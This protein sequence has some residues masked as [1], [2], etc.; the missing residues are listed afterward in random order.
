MAYKYQ[1]LESPLHIRLIHLL[2]GKAD[3]DIQLQISHELL[4]Q[5][6]Q[7]IS[8]RLSWRQLEQTLPPKWKVF[9]TLEGRFVFMYEADDIM[10]Q[11]N[12][13]L[14]D[15][16]FLW[17]HP[18][19]TIDPTLYEQPP[20][21]PAQPTFE[22]LSYVWGCQDDPI[23][24]AVKGTAGESLGSIKLGKN[25]AVALTHLRYQDKTRVLWVDAICINQS[26]DAERSTQVLRMSSIYHDCSRVIIWLGPEENNIALAFSEL[27]YAGSQVE[28]TTNGFLLSCPDATDFTWLNPDHPVPFSDEV[29][30]AIE[31]LG[32]RPW[33]HR[34][35][36]VQ[37]AV[38]ANRDSIMQSGDATISL[39]LFR[40]AVECLL[41]KNDLLKA[42]VS[43]GHFLVAARKPTGA[44]LAR[45]LDQYQTR[46][47]SDLHDK[48]YGLLAILPPKFAETIKPDYEQPVVELYKSCFLANISALRRWELRGCP[49]D[50]D[51]GHC[52]SWIPD[53]S[54]SDPYGRTV[55]RNSASGC[56]ALHYEYQEPNL[57]KLTGV[58]F[59][60]V[61]SVCEKTYDHRD[62]G[63]T[64][65]RTIR[66]W[67]PKCSLDDPYPSGGTFLDAFTATL[68]QDGRTDRRP[69]GFTPE[70]IKERFRGNLLSTASAPASELSHGDWVEHMIWMRAKGRAMVT[71]ESGS[72]GLSCTF[73]KPGESMATTD[74]SYCILTVLGDTICVFLGCDFPVLLRPC[75]DNTWKFLSDCYVLDLEAT[76]G[77]LGPLAAP[78]R[79]QVFYD[80]A[81]GYR[82][83]TRY[84]N[85]ETG[86]LTAEDPR[87]EPLEGW[88]RISLEELGRDLTGDDPEV[89]DFFRN[90]EDGGI[91]NSDPRL[92]PEALRCRG[93]NLETFVLS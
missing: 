54:Q 49:R 89:Y 37:E 61:K 33:F 63:E 75:E 21:N 36:T 71:T 80:P 78:W 5:P 70:H 30:S 88:Q 56:S 83:Y 18:D 60:I 45:I 58:R 27:A 2:P 77:L 52:P 35:W 24:A 72:I 92:E 74:L 1:A 57:L 9:E 22:A 32:G 64:A 87:L 47:C 55:Q 86:E 31:K 59:S 25:L 6:V 48:I 43:M 44:S 7:P 39:T 85:T 17:T 42:R 29:W 20:L 91:V 38:M 66:S 41:Q 65:I 46:I 16:A 79:A 51:K 69:N 10:S 90:T 67:E 76:Q 11:D 23:V 82:N 53:L 19:P 68:F 14:R 73:A 62:D 34:L 26:D 15:R 40:H 12:R 4:K 3:E 8:R 81:N 13:E 28:E 93:V 84:H 50:P